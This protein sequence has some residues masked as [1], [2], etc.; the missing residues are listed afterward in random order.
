MYF[1][2]ISDIRSSVGAV[3]VGL[4]AIR[5]DGNSLAMSGAISEAKNPRLFIL[6]VPI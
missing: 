2:V 3:S 1:I 4:G 6:G 5:D